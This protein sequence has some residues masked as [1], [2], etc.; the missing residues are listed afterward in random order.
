MRQLIGA[1]FSQIELEMFPDTQLP[2]PIGY[3]YQGIATR[4]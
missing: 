3:F 4:G 1:K 2:K